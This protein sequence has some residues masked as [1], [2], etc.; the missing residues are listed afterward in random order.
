MFVHFNY[1]L[2][3]CKLYIDIINVMLSLDYLSWGQAMTELRPSL[4][5]AWWSQLHFLFKSKLIERTSIHIS[6]LTKLLLVWIIHWFSVIS[7]FHNKII[8]RRFEFDIL[9]S[10]KIVL[11]PGSSQSL[12]I[13]VWL[14]FNILLSLIYRFNHL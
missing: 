8:F 14:L 3:I 2:L 12:I 4:G 9:V 13:W 5:L 6:K 1:C 7:N 11:L 10:T